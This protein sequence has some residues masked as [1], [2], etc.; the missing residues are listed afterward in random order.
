MAQASTAN[1]WR[2]EEEQ[3]AYDAIGKA[4]SAILEMGLKYNH[5]ELAGHIHGLQMFVNQHVLHR[6][7]SKFYSDWYGD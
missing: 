4:Y 1:A 2:T 7:D 5:D 6:F 3:A